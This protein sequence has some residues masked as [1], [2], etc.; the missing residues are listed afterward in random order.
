M[1]LSISL[2]V[3]DW[4]LGHIRKNNYCN[5]T[6]NTIFCLMFAEHFSSEMVCADA[7]TTAARQL[8]RREVENALLS[9]LMS[10]LTA[11]PQAIVALQAYIDG[12]KT[13]DKAFM[14]LYEA[15]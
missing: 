10:G 4:S 1:A 12:E 6:K 9:H 5:N 7:E 14:A 11:S 15:H 3:A 13:R 2:I 8:R